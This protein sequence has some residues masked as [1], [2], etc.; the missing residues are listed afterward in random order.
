MDNFFH[1]G[2]TDEEDR[3]RQ[4]REE[5]E[6]EERIRRDKQDPFRK[7]DPEPKEPPMKDPRPSEEGGDQTQR[8]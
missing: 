3:K 4:E 5:R 1:F 2:N 8:I 6:K 7:G